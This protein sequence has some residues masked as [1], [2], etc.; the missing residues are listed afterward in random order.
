MKGIRV[1]VFNNTSKFTNTYAINAYHQKSFEFE[2]RFWRGVLDT[3]L[4]DT[5]CQ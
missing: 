1:I 4:S 5:V 2:Y 3:T